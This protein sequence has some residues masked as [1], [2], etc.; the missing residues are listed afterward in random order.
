MNRFLEGISDIAIVEKEPTF[1]G[2]FYD[3]YLAPVKN[4][5]K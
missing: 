1:N 3:A 2:R 4:N 5:K